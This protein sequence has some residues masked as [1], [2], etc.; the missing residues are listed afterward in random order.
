MMYKEVKA[1]AGL[2]PNSKRPNERWCLTRALM[3]RENG[4]GPRNG[5]NH[6]RRMA[7]LFVPNKKD[8]RLMSLESKVFVSKLNKDGSKLITA[9]QGALKLSGLDR[10]ELILFNFF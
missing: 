3:R 8:K 7:N 5:G 2:P 9:C 6:L 4:L 10:F 1:L